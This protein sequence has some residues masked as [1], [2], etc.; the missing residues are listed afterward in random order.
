MIF[1][2]AK[3]AERKMASGNIN[4]LV[5]KIATSFAFQND[6]ESN[7]LCCLVKIDDLVIARFG[8]RRGIT[9]S[10]TVDFTIPNDYI[11]SSN[12]MISIIDPVNNIINGWITIGTTGNVTVNNLST[13][14]CIVDGSYIL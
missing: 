10:G 3:Y 14:N 7:G 12:R 1:S 11:P 4:K 9:T 2:S 8:F 5:S 13:N 6:W